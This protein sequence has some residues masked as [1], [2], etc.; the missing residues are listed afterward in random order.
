MSKN[1]PL[2]NGLFAIVDDEDFER[3]NKFRWHL[4]GQ[5]YVMRHIRKSDGTRSCQYLARFIMNDPEGLEVDH[6][7]GNK[8]DHRKSELRFCTHY[9][10]CC[11]KRKYKNNTSGFKG[12]TWD[13]KCSR[14]RARIRVHGR[15]ISLGRFREIKAAASAYNVASIRH[16]G[17]FGRINSLA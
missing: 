10:N 14:W 2:S 3:A 5:R 17:E 4:S 16:H 11:N 15:L 13:S 9:Q 7:H 12:V 1:I 6:L 8:L